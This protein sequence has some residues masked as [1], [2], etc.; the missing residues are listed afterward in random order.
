[1]KS[2]NNTL[3][4]ARNPQNPQNTR[5][6]PTDS[7]PPVMR[8]IIIETAR[9]SLV[10]E[11]LAGMVALG[12]VSTA[13]GG[14]IAI[15][16]MGDKTLNANLHILAIAKS[17]TGK[18][19]SYSTIAKPL[20]E[21]NRAELEHWKN[22]TA[23]DIQSEI[24]LTEERLKYEKNE[25]VKNGKSSADYKAMKSQLIKLQDELT[26]EPRLVAGETTEQK[27]GMLLSAQPHEAIGNHSAEAR[28]LIQIILGKFSGKSNATG[29]T[30]YL[31]GYSG[32]PYSIERA[33][34]PDISLAN[35]CISCL[36]MV[37][38]DVIQQLTSSDSM[39]TS[40]FLPRFLMADIKAELEDEPEAP[41]VIKADSMEQ[42]CELIDATLDR[43]RG[44]PE[45][46]I[47]EVEPTAQQ[48]LRNDLNRIRRT[49]RQNGIHA[50]LAS[51]V[52]RYGE[53]LRKI[54]LLLHVAEHA[55]QAHHHQVNDQ[56]AH[57]ACM[58]ADW[59]FREG[60]NILRA[61]Q[62]ERWQKVRARLEAILSKAG[63][64]ETIRN[65]K[66]RHTFTE[67]E[68]ETTIKMFPANINAVE[69]KNPRGGRPSRQVHLAC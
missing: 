5:P 60:M 43:F 55:E 28:G 39:T 56:T 26:K 45:K 47:I 6:F 61:G 42:W 59:F 23:A 48:I 49:G 10:P 14:G 9:A 44:S 15:R 19:M 63:G 58:I 25:C 68:I 33:G 40:G 41:H 3:S 21:S 66:D 8:D 1:M 35:P 18:G 54:A 27:L 57:N 69:V 17:G 29:E 50:D 12:V 22:N 34:R 24:E 2:E 4:P 30:M 16:S 38:P 13:A 64:S 37:Q 46:I 32:D 65:L 51:Y 62:M 36:F 11:S 31:A 52:A 20:N 7:F 53:N 67:S